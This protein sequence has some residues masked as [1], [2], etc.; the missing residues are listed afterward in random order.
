MSNTFNDFS[1]TWVLDTDDILTFHTHDDETSGLKTICVRRIEFFPTSSGDG[2]TF[3][4]VHLGGTPVLTLTADTFSVTTVGGHKRLSDDAGAALDS[5]LIAAGDIL[6]ITDSPTS[7][8]NKG[9][10]YIVAVDGSNVYVDTE[11]GQNAMT[12]EANK[13]YTLNVYNPELAMTMLSPSESGTYDS[14]PL[15]TVVKDFGDKGRYFP[16]LIMTAIVGTV[17]IYLK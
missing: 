10:W 11:D 16:N 9:L 5:S 13:V 7:G 17:H 14:N 8:N 4:T 3:T 15:V 1:H 6:E 12:V 2:V